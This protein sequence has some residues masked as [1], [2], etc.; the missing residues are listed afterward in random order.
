MT[1][2]QLMWKY[3]KFVKLFLGSDYLLTRGIASPTLSGRVQTVLKQ[4]KIQDRVSMN[5][6]LSYYLHLNP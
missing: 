6:A 4:G 5:Q 3:L 1:A 2:V